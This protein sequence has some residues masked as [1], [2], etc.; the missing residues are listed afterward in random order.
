MVGAQTAG[1]G[2]GGVLEFLQSLGAEEGAALQMEVP[3]RQS[4]AEG[5]HNAGDHR[6]GDVA[7]QLLLKG[8]EHR[9]V[10]EGATLN[11]DVLTQIV[12]GGGGG[13]P[14]MAQ[15]GGKNPAGIKDALDKAVEVLK[16]Q[17]K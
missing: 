16:N 11:H 14:N 12:G 17:I 2:A 8:P 9:V 6:A 13:R 10:E 1:G 3:G 4:G 7:A 15:A 5:A